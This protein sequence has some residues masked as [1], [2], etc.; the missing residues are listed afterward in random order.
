VPSGPFSICSVVS[1]YGEGA[2]VVLP[3]DKGAV[4]CSIGVPDSWVRPVNCSEFG[5]APGVDVIGFLS[6]SLALGE[7]VVLIPSCLKSLWRF[8]EDLDADLPVCF[9]LVENVKFAVEAGGLAG[10][11]RGTF[12]RGEDWQG[13]S[14]CGVSGVASIDRRLK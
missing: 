12:F 10:D 1:P 14:F 13:G 7:H 11:E 4:V 6:I 8:D 5:M 9:D 3:R 2:V